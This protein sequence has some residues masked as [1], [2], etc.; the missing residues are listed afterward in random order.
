MLYYVALCNMSLVE[1]VGHGKEDTPHP[2]PA[3]P[4]VVACCARGWKQA[5]CVK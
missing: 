1:Q 2:H 3:A 5:A 4:L